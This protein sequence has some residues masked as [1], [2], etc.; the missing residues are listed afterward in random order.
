MKKKNT[1]RKHIITRSAAI[2]AALCLCLPGA[3]CSKYIAEL[4][5]PEI[6]S[7]EVPSESPYI[8][9]S[10]KNSSAPY[11]AT[12]TG[13]ESLS[14]DHEMPIVHNDA[15]FN[16]LMQYH[17][18]GRSD[19]FE[20]YADDGYTID[21]DL[22]LYRFSLPYVYTSSVVMD[23]N[24][25]F[26]NV[27]I[28]YYPGTKIA[29]AY[30]NNDYIDLNED[31]RQTFEIALDYV[32]NYVNPEPDP[33]KKE[34]LIHDF[35][36]ASTTYTN[37]SSNE[38]IPRHCTAVGLLLDGKA[39]CQGYTDCFYMMGTM[40]GLNVDKQS[41]SA[42]GNL[43]V[44]NIIELD[45]K[46][47]SLDIT[48]DDTTFFADG[49]GYPAYIYFNS[50]NDI[51]LRTHSVPKD[52]ELIP[53]ESTSDEYYFYYSPLFDLVGY[54]SDDTVAKKEIAALLEDC[55]QKGEPYVS[56]MLDGYDLQAADIVDEIKS[57]IPGDPGRITITTYQVQNTTYFLGEPH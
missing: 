27:S 8:T 7:M 20:F 42:E 38:N 24:R 39:N 29:D 34:R 18:D 17:L 4:L 21:N 46:W 47:Y 35:I 15:E 31:E 55:Y 36:C 28:S 2:L 12:P 5:F 10:E 14:Y 53:I 52:N 44:W 30:I 16:I 43:H 11:T 45:G 54:A 50:A 32:R 19:Y 33:V 9:S 23:N 1:N 22:L 37:P 57:Y 41:G 56:Y 26:W 13:I 51:L 48:Y 6:T 40:A 49:S 3:G 25:E